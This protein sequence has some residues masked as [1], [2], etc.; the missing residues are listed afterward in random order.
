MCSREY[1]KSF[2]NSFFY[3]ATPVAAFEFCCGVR[4]EFLKKKVRGEIALELISLF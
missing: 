1:W 3:R 2:R 4:K